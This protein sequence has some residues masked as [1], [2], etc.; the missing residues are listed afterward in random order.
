MYV[1]VGPAAV[2]RRSLLD[3]AHDVA[4]LHDEQLLAVDLHLGSAPLAEQ[5]PVALLE[6][7]G[8]QLA[9]LVACAWPDRDYLTLLRLLGSGIG[10]DDAAGGLG[11]AV[12]ALQLTPSG[13][14]G[15][16]FLAL[17]QRE[18]QGAGVI[19]RRGAGCQE[20][21]Q[22]ACYVANR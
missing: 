4:L 6:L 7:D 5:N 14:D 1:L 3:H 11:F 17:H 2:L 18:C 22:D 15:I 13:R 8:D 9:G 16:M 19:R 20:C 21:N 10:D 12:E